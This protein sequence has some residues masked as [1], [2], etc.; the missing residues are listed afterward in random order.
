[1]DE[2]NASLDHDGEMALA[3]TVRSLKNRGAA[4]VIVTH[5]P[6]IL[7]SCD[8]VLTLDAGGLQATQS[9]QAPIQERAPARLRL[10]SR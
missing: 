10:V 8:R 9:L 5:R 1:M 4:I 2:P 6:A 7:A 3:E